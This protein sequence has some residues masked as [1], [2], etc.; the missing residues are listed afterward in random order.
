[1]PPPL[2]CHHTR[3]K[4]ESEW[5][6]S[7]AGPSELRADA[8]GCCCCNKLKFWGRLL[9]PDQQRI[10]EEHDAPLAPILDSYYLR[11]GGRRE[12][13]EQIVLHAGMK[14]ALK[15]GPAGPSVLTSLQTF[16]CLNATFISSYGYFMVVKLLI[17]LTN[18]VSIRRSYY[19]ESGP[20]VVSVNHL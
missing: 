8:G 19:H 9:Q 3:V 10:L 18:P 7:T 12:R 17:P 14:P 2:H 16:I 6:K 20:P 13:Q 1:M 5:E 4:Y 11:D 15:E